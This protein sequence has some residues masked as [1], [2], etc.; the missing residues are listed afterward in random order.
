MDITSRL[1]L[2][3]IEYH[4]KTDNLSTT[5]SLNNSDIFDTPQFNQYLNKLVYLSSLFFVL[6]DSFHF[7]NIL[8]NWRYSN[9]SHSQ[10]FLHQPTTLS[11]QH[12]ALYS[13]ESYQSE[14]KSNSMR[15]VTIKDKDLAIYMYL[16]IDN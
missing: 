6:I 3:Q 10:S 7:R 11:H 4:P 1:T 9:P 12:Q 13:L 5:G 8:R 15:T 2:S 14:Q 16:N